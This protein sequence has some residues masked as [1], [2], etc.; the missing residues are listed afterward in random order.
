MGI[1]FGSPA[2]KIC[3]GEEN[4]QN[5]SRFLTNLDY[6]GE[7]L[8]NGSTYRKSKEYFINYNAI[9]VGWKKFGEL[10]C[11]KM[12]QLLIFTHPSG[13]FWEKTFQPLGRA[14][15]SYFYTR[16]RWKGEKN[17][18]NFGAQ[19]SYSCLYSPTQADIF[20][21][22]HFDPWGVLPPQIFTRVTDWPSLA[23]AHPNWDGVAWRFNSPYAISYWWS[24]E[25]SLSI[26]SPYR[27]IRLQKAI[28]CNTSL[29]MRDITW[30][31]PL[32]KMWVHIF[33][34]HTQLPIHCHTFWA[35]TKNKGC[36]LVRPSM[37][38]AKSS[39][40]LTNFDALGGLWQEL[41]KVSIFFTAKDTSFGESTLF[42]PFCFKIGC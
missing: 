19:K 35:P 25:P 34:S 4:V 33:I 23:S 11:T 26:S 1:T 2:P 18:V 15:P 36:L 29:R 27:D 42:E 24:M 8:R 16:D 21:R 12:L 10:W 9:N 13:H 30:L 39:E 22:K 28:P 3:Q 41:W 6:D 17:L 38:K 31:V 5:L 20:G 14:A 32:C 7:Y 37:L 40:N